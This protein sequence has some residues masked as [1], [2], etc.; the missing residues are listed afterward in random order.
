MSATRAL[1]AAAVAA[2]TCSTAFADIFTMTGTTLGG[3]TFNRPV[4]D[5]SELS[6]TGTSV[7]YDTFSFSVGS[8]GSYSFLTTA[9]FDSFVV[10]YESAFNPAAPLSN[11]RVANDDLVSTSTSGL[12]FNLA[13]GVQY[14]YVV[15]SFL[16]GDA[17]SYSTTIGGPGSV[18][19]VP[20]PAAYA[21]LLVGLAV[22][23]LA[24]R[25]A[26]RQA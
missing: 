5:L 7:N 4:E 21:M 10:L 6:T 18:V 17:G 8:A 9:T 24:R 2:C 12:S 23:G 19:P 13:T 26:S 3:A 22:V 14:H 1:I 20:E 25:G 15:T 16:N 11:A